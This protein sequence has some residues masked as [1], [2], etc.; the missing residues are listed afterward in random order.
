MKATTASTADTIHD[1]TAIRK[2]VV[3]MI[4]ELQ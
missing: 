3:K 4:M 2:E 1:T